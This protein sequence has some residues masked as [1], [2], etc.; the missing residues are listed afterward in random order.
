MHVTS[1]LRAVVEIG[2]AEILREAGPQ[3]KSSFF[4]L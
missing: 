2:V 3:V 1:A 4:L